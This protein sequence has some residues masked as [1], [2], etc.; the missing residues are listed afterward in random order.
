MTSLPRITLRP[1]NLEFRVNE[2]RLPL[3][4][5]FLTLIIHLIGNPHYGFFR[6]E[7]YFIV[8]GLRP[9]FGYVDQPPIIPLL[10]AAT[11]LFGHS[12]F[13]LRAVPALFA[14]GGAYVT[15]LLVIEMQGGLFAI[16]LASL[17]FLFA[18]VLLNFGMKA[19]TD[20]VGLWLWPL[21]A[22]YTLRLA[23][24]ADSR[25]WV[26][27]G[28][29]GGVCVESKY[30]VVFFAFALI[31]GLLLTTSRKILATPWFPVGVAIAGV[32]ALP[33]FWWQAVHGFPMWA[34]LQAGQHGKDTLPSPGLYL[35][36]ELVITGPFLAGVWI[37]GLAWTFLRPQLRYFGWAYVALI[38]AMM[39]LHGKDYYPA[40]YYPILIAAGGTAVESWV[41]STLLR[42]AL[43]SAV[44]IAGIAFLPLSL[45]VLRED[46]LAS[47][48]AII[49]QT[50]HLSRDALATE[51]HA[52][53]QL[54][55]DFADMHGWLP[56][57]ATVADVYDSL[58][59]NERS[60][61]VILTRNYGEAAA[62]DFL[63]AP[64][65]LP[66]AIS[67]HNNYWL[68]G[69][70]GMRGN[71]AIDVRGDCQ[72]RLHLY[73]FSHLVAVVSDPWSEPY[74]QSMH[75]NICMG[76]RAPLAS[77]WPSLKNYN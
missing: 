17:S 2:R 49:G 25:W 67:G 71:V 42:I 60:Q 51:R 38:F 7:L 5:A 69:T 73:R 14:A 15:C 52:E 13:F 57:V 28:L 45:P 23:R 4:A 18:G 31:V 37:C 64:F 9:A 26:V 40:N 77:V 43:A 48:E 21:I 68:W 47:R 16:A 70:H 61:T 19:N 8:C 6:D 75:I 11:Q 44:V 65:H 41:R 76:I 27:I 22:L 59:P 3:T 62:I 1:S 30:S 53:P 56:L 33:N 29:A 66:P 10:A 63:G 20:E 39:L 32:I 54:P 34:V 50:L 46:Q 55:D 74:E 35:Y 24:G 72:T 36:Q 58:P 12:L